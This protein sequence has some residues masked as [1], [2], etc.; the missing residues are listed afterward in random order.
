M[1]LLVKYGHTE[2]VPVCERCANTL[3]RAAEFCSAVG[4]NEVAVIKN[5][6]SGGNGPAQVCA[7]SLRQE[8]AGT[9]FLLHRDTR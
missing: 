8:R 5:F 9:F 2:P 4:R 3:C 7:L 1:V 6:M